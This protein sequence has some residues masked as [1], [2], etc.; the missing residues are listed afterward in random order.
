[1]MMK[2]LR[3][4]KRRAVLTRLFSAGAKDDE[5]LAFKIPNFNKTD[6]AEA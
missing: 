6:A 5:D 1:M 4:S 2:S 3:L